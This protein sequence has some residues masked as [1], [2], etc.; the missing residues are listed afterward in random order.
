MRSYILITALL[1][2]GLSYAQQTPHYSLYVFNNYMINPA[3][4]GTTECYEIKGG[5]RTQWLGFESAPQTMFI[6]AQGRLKGK[7]RV[8]K[9]SFEGIG[10]YL[11]KDQTGPMGNIGG[12][13]SYAFHFKIQRNLNASLGLSIGVMQFSVISGGLSP[14]VTPDPA[15]TSTTSILPD[16]NAGIW[17]YSDNFFAGLA[18]RQLLPVN[19]TGTNNRLINHLYFTAG[20]SIRLNNGISVIPSVH[21]RTG[22]LTP[23]Q[24][25][26]TVRVDW[27]NKFWIGA[28]YRK[29]DGI[30]GLVG[31]NITQYFQ[32][33]YA[34]DYTLSKIGNYSTGSHEIILSFIPACNNSR[35][36]HI[37]PAYF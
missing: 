16:A 33:G 8:K 23:I 12:H 31:F 2:A 37:C 30:A 35:S 14:V 29:I 26:G 24:I 11:I 21:A 1:L 15:V 19:L 7:K 17:V 36:R 20:Y 4:T 32:L 6:S 10:G 3:V 22:L 13:V 9:A 27:K 25:D 18:A 28:N 34:Y 5:Y